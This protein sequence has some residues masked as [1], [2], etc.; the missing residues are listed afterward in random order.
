MG[1]RTFKVKD[2]MGE[3]IE[4]IPEFFL[5]EVCDFMGKEMTIP[6]I[7]FY[8]MEDGTS[9]PYATLTKSFGE[10]IGMKNCAYIDTNNCSFAPQLLVAG[11]A[12]D[13]GFTKRSGFC[14]YPLWLLDEAFLREIGGEDYQRY[15]EEFDQYM[16]DWASE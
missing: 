12:K 7:E 4:V 14:V 9:I 2:F 11:V 3:E 15:C 1:N 5:Y 10:F 16:S 6:G 8:A 13:T